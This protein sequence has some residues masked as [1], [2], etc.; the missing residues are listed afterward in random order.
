MHATVMII[1]LHNNV[2]LFKKANIDIKINRI[3]VCTRKMCCCVQFSADKEV[4]V[5]ACV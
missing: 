5:G 2:N 1:G 4:C 3:H